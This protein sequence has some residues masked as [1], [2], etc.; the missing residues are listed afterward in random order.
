VRPAP[1]GKALTYYAVLFAPGEQTVPPPE[2]LSITDELMNCYSQHRLPSRIGARGRMLFE[3]LLARFS[4]IERRA[5]IAAEHQL[6]AFLW[7]LVWK[8]EHTPPGRE[9]EAADQTTYTAHVRRALAIIESHRE[10]NLSIAVLARE[11][12]VSQEHLTRSFAHQVGQPPLAYHRRTRIEA[13]V[14]LLLNSR[15]PVKE[16]AWD[17]GFAGSTQFARTFRSVTGMS[18][19]TFRSRYFATTPTNYAARAVSRALPPGPSRG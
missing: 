9:E 16:I 6:A 13:A 15:R 4:H 5:R 10:R 3:E 17:L 8:T 2:P 18:P 12:G 11:V 19:T 1:Q 7:E 14:S